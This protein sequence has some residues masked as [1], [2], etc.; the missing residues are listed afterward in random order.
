MAP[1]LSASSYLMKSPPVQ[2]PDD[3]GRASVE[4]FIRGDVER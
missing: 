4:A 3:E 1:L 2:R